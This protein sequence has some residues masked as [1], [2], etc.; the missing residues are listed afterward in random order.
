MVQLPVEAISLPI[1]ATLGS[2]ADQ[3]PWLER[4]KEK[5]GTTAIKRRKQ[6]FK[7]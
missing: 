5:R 3:I 1:S 6:C 2:S 7:I 4:P